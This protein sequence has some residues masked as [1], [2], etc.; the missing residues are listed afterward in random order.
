M[1][2]SFICWGT[3]RA[4]GASCSPV[5]LWK[6]PE[7][8]PVHAVAEVDEYLPVEHWVADERPPEAQYEPA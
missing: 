7:P 8:Q 6:R 3:E 4:R 1:I 2:R 5:L